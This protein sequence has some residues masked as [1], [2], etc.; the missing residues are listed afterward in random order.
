MSYF[1][2]NDDQIKDGGSGFKPN[3]YGFLITKSEDSPT[4]AGKKRLQIDIDLFDL[5]TREKVGKGIKYISFFL[6]HEVGQGQLASLCKAV[7]VQ[8]LNSPA[9]LVNKGGV[10]LVGFEQAYNDE[11]KHYPK[12]AFGGFGCWFSKEKLSPS[13]I[14]DGK[15][16]PQAFMERLSALIEAPYRGQDGKQHAT[17]PATYHAKEEASASDEPF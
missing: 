8:A 12:P 14:K 3:A 2:F 4:Q 11:T 10:V 9:D 5:T 7:K 15:T 13:E 16:E 1:S 6:E 17:K